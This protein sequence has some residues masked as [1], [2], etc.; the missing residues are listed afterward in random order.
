MLRRAL[1]AGLLAASP[2]L[3][4]PDRPLRL[5]VAY[6]AGGG[7][8]LMA[9][10]IAQRM[11]A[12]LGQP[13]VVENRTG[14]SGTIGAQAVAT[15]RPDGHTLLF[16]TTSEMALRPVLDRQLPF[17]AERDF[18]PVALLGA[19]PVVLAVN[20]GLPVQS[21]ADLIALARAQP[22]RLG[23]AT[24]G[25]GSL[26]HLTGEFFQL[27][28]RLDLLHV[29]YR[30]AAPAV[31]DTAAG[32][33]AMVFSGLPPVLPLVREGRLRILA[34][35]TPRRFAAIPDVPTLA[36]GGLDGFDM[37]NVVGIVAPRGTPGEAILALNA[38]ANAA[39]SDPAVREVFARNGAETLGSTPEA[40]ASAIRA[41]RDR[42][43]AIIRA[44]GMA[45]D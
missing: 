1:L 39:V 27:Q 19:T 16:V 10:A 31:T 42:F 12:V 6:P 26:M 17:D 9:R 41:A 38:A 7:T 34:V 4:F 44:T 5:V 15:A 40:Y 2:A 3:A 24:T 18:V 36:E 37:A 45:L 20:A 21:V 35:S 22:G 14:A 13:V 30:G 29:P 25:T 32:Q 8:D 11:A 28:A 23:Y 43:A 33:V